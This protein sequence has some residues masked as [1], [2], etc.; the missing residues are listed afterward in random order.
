[1]WM[2]LDKEQYDRGEQ[3]GESDLRTLWA[4]YDAHV[5]RCGGWREAAP[6]SDQ[7]EYLN[8]KMDHRVCRHSG[9]P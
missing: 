4:D 8:R 9:D 5:E 7:Q 6:E 2:A 1:M 3:R